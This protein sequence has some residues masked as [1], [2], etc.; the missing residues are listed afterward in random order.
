M[1]LDKFDKSNGKNHL[2]MNDSLD[3]MNREFNKYYQEA[4]LESNA[5][6]SKKNFLSPMIMGRQ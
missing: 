4:M 3:N 6:S 5:Q 1:G 2:G